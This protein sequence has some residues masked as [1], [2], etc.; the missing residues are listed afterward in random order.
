M[1]LVE[2]LF[3]DCTIFKFTRKLSDGCKLELEH[4]LDS[5]FF[6]IW[7]DHTDIF[8]F[9]VECSGSTLVQEAYRPDRRLLNWS[10][11]QAGHD[12]V[13]ILCTAA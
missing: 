12:V 9:F 2:F 7:W 5:K 8:L 6:L 10:D 11:E 1:I 4:S 13:C 3:S